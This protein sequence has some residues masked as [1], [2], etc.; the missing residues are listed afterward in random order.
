MKHDEDYLNQWA[1]HEEI[2]EFT[3]RCVQ[4]NMMAAATVN[5]VNFIFWKLG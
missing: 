2:N 4:N 1:K 3:Q 5:W